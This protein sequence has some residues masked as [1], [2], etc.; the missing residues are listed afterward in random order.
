MSPSWI[1]LER[2]SIHRNDERSL[3]SEV[4]LVTLLEKLLEGPSI[5]TWRI[6]DDSSG[7]AIAWV[8][9]KTKRNVKTGKGDL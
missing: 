1:V 8:A 3:A 5:I 2:L 7:A 6:A 9:K 4:G